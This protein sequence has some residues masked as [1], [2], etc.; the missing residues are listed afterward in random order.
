[1]QSKNPRICLIVPILLGQQGQFYFAIDGRPLGWRSKGEYEMLDQ[2]FSF[3]T[4]V[5]THPFFKWSKVMERVIEWCFMLPRYTLLDWL[6]RQLIALIVC[7]WLEPWNQ[8]EH[9][10]A[11]YWGEWKQFW[12]WAKKIFFLSEKKESTVVRTNRHQTSSV[13]N[14]SRW[15]LQQSPQGR[16]EDLTIY[17]LKMTLRA[18]IL[19]WGHNIKCIPLN[20]SKNLKARLEWTMKYRDSKAV[21]PRLTFSK[22]IKW[23]GGRM[24]LLMIQ[25]IHAHQ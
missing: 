12:S 13:K 22:V 16:G 3:Q 23:F 8:H 4:F 5:W 21:E 24:D 2:N 17:H 6:F 18:E 9:Q 19:Y 7:S 14:I 11:V 25:N 1:M 15:H 20:S 10:R